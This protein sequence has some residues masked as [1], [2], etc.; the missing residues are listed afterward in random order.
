MPLCCTSQICA[1]DDPIR[2]VKWTSGY[3]GL[4]AR[5]FLKRMTRLRSLTVLF[6]SCLLDPCVHYYASTGTLSFSYKT[7]GAFVQQFKEDWEKIVRMLRII[8]QLHAPTL[9]NRHIQLQAC[10]LHHV[11]LA[12]FGRYTVTLKWVPASTIEKRSSSGV[13]IPPAPRFRQGL[14]E[15]ELSEVDQYKGQVVNPHRRMKYFLQDMFN[16]EADLHSFMNVSCAQIV[17]LCSI[18]LYAEV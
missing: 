4:L 17:F 1:R 2:H 11:K 15:I 3:V 9:S 8:R 7:R 14:Y 12:Y 5:W 16:R 18:G 13:L 10:H 6:T